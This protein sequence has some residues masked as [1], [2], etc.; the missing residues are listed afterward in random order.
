MDEPNILRRRGLQVRGGCHDNTRM[1]S[2]PGKRDD[3]MMNDD[4]DEPLATMR[5]ISPGICFG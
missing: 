2:F 1:R 4:G 3:M 5:G